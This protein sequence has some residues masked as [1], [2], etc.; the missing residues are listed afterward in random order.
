M[1][2]IWKDII[3]YENI[4]KISNLGKIISNDRILNLKNGFKRF[5]KGREMK[6]T[7]T[8][9]GYLCVGLSKNSKNKTFEIHRLIAIHFIENPNNYNIVNH[10]DGNKLNNNINNLEWVNLRENTTHGNLN[11]NNFT[12]KYPCVYKPKNSKKFIAEINYNGKKNYLGSYNT[13]KEAHEKV[14]NFQKENSIINKYL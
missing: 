4:Y 3:G 7:E 14:L 12:S 6:L 8:H 5:E 2:E 10:I 11:K 13:E 9:K 1:V